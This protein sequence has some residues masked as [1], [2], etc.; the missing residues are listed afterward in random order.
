MKHIPLKNEKLLYDRFSIDSHA[1]ETEKGLFLWYAENF[2]EG[3]RVGTRVFVDRLLDPETPENKP[4]G[5]IVPTFEEG[6]GHHSVIKYK[7]EYYAI[8]H[9]RDYNDNTTRTARICRL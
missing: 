5:K 7:G 3:E 1:V 2:D 9:G 8:Y 6:T 4:V